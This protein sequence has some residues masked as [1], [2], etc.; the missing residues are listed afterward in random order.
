ME[1][2]SCREEKKKISKNTLIVFL[3][4]Y[5]FLYLLNYFTPMSFGDDYLYS[6]IWQGQPM[7]VP[8][9]EDAVRVSS[10]HDLLASQWSHYMT[11]GGR[12]V[13][14]VI[15]QFFLWIGKDVFNFFN[16][17]M[18]VVLIAEIYW[19]IYKGNITADIQPKAVFWIFFCLWAFSPGFAPIFFWLTGACNYLWTSVI[20][21]GFLIPYLRKYYCLQGETVKQTTM[22]S[23]GMFCY[24]IITGWT[25]ENTVCWVIL[26]LGAFLFMFKKCNSSEKWMYSGLAGLMIGYALLI[27]SPGNFRRMLVEKEV[28]NLLTTQLMTEQLGILFT[29]LLFQFILWYFV[30]CSRRKLKRIALQEQKVKKEVIL[31]TVLCVMAFAMSAIMV[32]SPRFPPRSGFFGTVLLVFA[33]GIILRIQ[34]EFG[35]ALL[36]DGA[37][38]FLSCIGIIFFV[39]S[40]V[41]TLRHY[42]IT[43]G[44]MQEFLTS[45]PQMPSNRVVSIKPFRK[46]D[47]LEERMSGFH[48]LYYDLA[49]DENNPSNTAFAR[50]YRIKGIRMIQ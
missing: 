49:A 24:G 27:F 50:Y 22:F 8:L 11:W 35:I 6:F 2:E 16:A 47:S 38:Q 9:P 29:I 42:Y 40:A 31:L 37:K 21:L 10:W 23:L 44:Q 7:N 48:L 28:N 45:L 4:I 13:A 30:L 25:N 17:L 20:L 46:A 12:T 19:C 1:K 39:I 41:V 34:K 36:Q 15:A 3:A 32:F 18:G 26:V 33:S 43:H 14:H 5:L